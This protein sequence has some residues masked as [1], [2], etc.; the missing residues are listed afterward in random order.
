MLTGVWG[1]E[2]QT[3]EYLVSMSI[4]YTDQAILNPLQIL[5]QYSLTGNPSEV[6][7]KNIY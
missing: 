5:F 1:E 7:K 4:F 6:N 3:N 2:I